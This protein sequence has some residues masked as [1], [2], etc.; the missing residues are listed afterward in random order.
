MLSPSSAIITYVM[1]DKWDEH[2]SSAERVRYEVY[3]DGCWTGR[4]PGCSS[5]A[6][7]EPRAVEEVTASHTIKIDVIPSGEK[8]KT[9]KPARTDVAR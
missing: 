6:I 7:R 5:S 4:G 3:W 1:A 8:T 9:A 2:L